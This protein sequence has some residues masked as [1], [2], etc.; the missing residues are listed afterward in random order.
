ME[1]F[2]EIAEILR[3]DQEYKDILKLSK[4]IP[5]HRYD[6]FKGEK[7]YFFVLAEMVEYLLKRKYD[8]RIDSEE[9]LEI[10]RALI[11]DNLIYAII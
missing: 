2:R 4:W 6:F 11:C 5:P 7:D 8:V 10:L 9:E 1:K 3:K